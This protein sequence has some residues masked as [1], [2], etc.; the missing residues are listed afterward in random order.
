M[1][2]SAPLVDHGVFSFRFFLKSFSDIR[3]TRDFLSFFLSFP[4]LSSLS[5]SLSFFFFFSSLNIF[6]PNFEQD[7]GS[8]MEKFKL[9]VITTNTVESIPEVRHNHARKQI[10]DEKKR[11]STH[12]AD[13]KSK[14]CKGWDRKTQWKLSLY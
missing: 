12:I 4:L 7:H 8:W 10:I 13:V 3:E 2:G 9:W 14:F 11:D 6:E 1:D 5:L